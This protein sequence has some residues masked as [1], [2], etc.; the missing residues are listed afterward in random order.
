MVPSKTDL[1]WIKFLDNLGKMPVSD[2]SVKM[3]MNRV[4][5]KILFDGSDA[6]KKQMISDAHDFFTKNEATMKADIQLIFG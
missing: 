3:L 6:V 5:T 4:K 2:L 1:K